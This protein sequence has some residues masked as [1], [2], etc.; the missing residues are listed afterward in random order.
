VPLVDDGHG[1]VGSL[2]VLGISDVASDAHTASVD[3]AECYER[4][5]VVVVD[6]GEVAQLGRGQPWLSGQEPK[7]PGLEAQSGEAVGQQFS[8]IAGELPDPDR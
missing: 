7:L 2:R 3:E 6:R 1:N 4:L 5:V 8:V